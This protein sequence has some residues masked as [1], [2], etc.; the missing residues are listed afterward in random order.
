MFHLRFIAGSVNIDLPARPGANLESPIAG[1]EPAVY[2]TAVMLVLLPAITT[3]LV[4]LG[5]IVG[6][7]WFW[8]A[9]ERDTGGPSPAF[10]P[11]VVAVIPARDEA[12]SI[13]RS[14]ASL[15]GQDY[16]GRF[17]IIVVDDQSADGTSAVAQQA[18]ASAGSSDRL[19]V[20]AGRALPSGWTGKLWA[21]KQGIDEARSR[22]PTYLLLTD[23]DITYARDT[24][25]RLVA[26]AEKDGLVLNSLMA[27]LRAESLAERALVPAF[28]FFFQMLYPFA[29]VNRPER[30]TAAAAGG[31]MLVRRAALEAAGGIESIRGALIDDCTLARRLKQQGPIRLSLT[32]RV[33]SI[34]AYPTLSDIRRMVARSAY[35]QLRYSPLILAATIA[36]MALTYLAPVLLALFAGGLAAVLGLAAW[37]M[38]AVAFQPTLRLYRASPIWGILLPAIALLYMAFTLDSAYQHVRGAGGMWKGRVQAGLQ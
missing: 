29:W 26:R 38:M 10:W 5:L 32:G 16:P 25:S 8:L 7:G 11:E 22:A 13:G 34:R 18:A 12:E 3:F 4:W 19:R 9:G 28:I 24:L 14:V 17:S 30:A 1:M 36:G 2:E 20:L 6:R 37:V 15:L 21:V 27:R 31:C 33:E 23:A 35:A